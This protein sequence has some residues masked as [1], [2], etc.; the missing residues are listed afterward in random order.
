MADMVL[1]RVQ[2]MSFLPKQFS[3]P[4]IASEKDTS[5]LDLIFRG[6]VSDMTTHTGDNHFRVYWS[7]LKRKI[8]APSRL[9][10]LGREGATRQRFST[11]KD[12]MTQNTSPQTP[13]FALQQFQKSNVKFLCFSCGAVRAIS[14]VIEV[15]QKPT[16]YIC[17]CTL[18]CGHSRDLEIAV[19][20]SEAE[21]ATFC[22]DENRATKK[23]DERLQSQ[24]R[25][26]AQFAPFV[27][28]D[29]RFNETTAV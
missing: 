9:V 1:D 25:L 13:T 15:Q 2:V 16:S 26:E 14:L 11:E 28:Q 6:P 22:A 24:V 27:V 7:R 29:L 23:T 19:I 5:F 20:R 10:L 8:G 18:E 21:Q 4:R 12:S 3:W 17:T